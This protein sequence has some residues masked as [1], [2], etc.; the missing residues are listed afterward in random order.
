MESTRRSVC[1]CAGGS[2]RASSSARRELPVA[3]WRLCC[4][5]TTVLYCTEP[6]PPHH[7]THFAT[8]TS[9]HP[10]TASYKNTS[11][12]CYN[13]LC[14]YPRRLNP[15]GHS[16]IRPAAATLSLPAATLSIAT[17]LESVKRDCVN[18][19]RRTEAAHRHRNARPHIC[20]RSGGLP[21]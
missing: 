13:P 16:P 11:S 14:R 21:V 15:P 5:L 7:P 3:S 10:P 6:P 12:A 20:R 8:P 17:H 18:R 2:R 9:H 1:T 4:S 19:K